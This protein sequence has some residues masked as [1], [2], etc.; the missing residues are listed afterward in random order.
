MSYYK[1]NGAR[2]RFIADRLPVYVFPAFV[3]SGRILVGMALAGATT[4]LLLHTRAGGGPIFWWLGG[5]A[6]LASLILV[7]SGIYAVNVIPERHGRVVR[8]SPPPPSP[9]RPD[10][11][12]PQQQTR[13]SAEESKQ[14]QLDR[15]GYLLVHRWRLI[16]E[17]QFERIVARQKS[18]GESLVSILASTGFLTDEDLENLLAF[19]AAKDP[20]Y[21]APRHD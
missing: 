11:P 21:N 7:I 2:S 13:D 17:E 15:L 14:K 6:Y 3:G 20:W 16:D 19:Q 4:V 8:V 5:I 18:T 1:R 10:R 12:P 9:P